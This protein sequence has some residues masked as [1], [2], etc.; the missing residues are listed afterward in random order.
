VRVC[1]GVGVCEYGYVLEGKICLV[2]LSNVQT[3]TVKTLPFYYKPRARTLNPPTAQPTTTQTQPNTQMLTNTYPRI[4]THTMLPLPTHTHT[5]TQPLCALLG[6]EDGP[7]QTSSDESIAR[8]AGVLTCTSV[9]IYSL[10]SVPGL[11]EPLG[12]AGAIQ[13]LVSVVRRCGRIS[14]FVLC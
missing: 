1:C 13:G 6:S 12:E 4:H 2:C 10:A 8:S 9:G 3:R 14:C 5:H 11:R 7:S